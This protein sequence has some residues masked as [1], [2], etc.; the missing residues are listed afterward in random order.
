MTQSA[1]HTPRRSLLFVPANNGRALSKAQ[2]LPA[3][4]V[5]VDLEDA[6]AEADKDTAREALPGIVLSLIH[7]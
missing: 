7:I 6:V 4:A 5:A 2:S 3:D 1:N